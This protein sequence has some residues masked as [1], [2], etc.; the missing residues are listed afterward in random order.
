MKIEFEDVYKTKC[1]LEK[2]PVKDMI[3][4]GI[5]EL[6]LTI[7][8]V[9]TGKGFYYHP[10]LPEDWYVNSRMHLTKDQIKSLL[11]HLEKFVKIGEL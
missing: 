11:P 8:A 3:W 9:D 10:V 2:S 6:R 1:S 4:L 5:D 7:P